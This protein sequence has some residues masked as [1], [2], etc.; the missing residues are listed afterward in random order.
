M[1]FYKYNGLGN[2]FILVE[3]SAARRV[4]GPLAKIMCDRHFG[5]GADGVLA[6]LPGPQP[7]ITAKM[8]IFN[9]D[10]TIAEMCG[11]GIRC[12]AYHLLRNG[13]TTSNKMQISTGAGIKTV[14]VEVKSAVEA[15]V[16]VDMGQVVYKGD[17]LPTTTTDGWVNC[18][19]PDGKVAKLYPASAGNPH[20]IIMLGQ[21][22]D[23]LE[24]AQQYGSFLEHHPLFP[25]KTNVEF[26]KQLSKDN[27]EVVVH[28]RGC[29]ITM[30]CGTGA[31]SVASVMMDYFGAPTD[32]VTVKLPGGELQFRRLSSGNMEMQG[33]TRLVFSG[34]AYL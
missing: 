17:N 10:G 26:V 12:L 9:S 7:E 28:E 20:C 29:G 21:N 34:E 3:G 15:L 16:T 24:W 5:I 6:V 13:W 18:R 30:A 11:N 19:L 25:A 31:T 33:K 32:K 22:D 8:V 14:Q 27:Y 2:D 1:H 4:N 23:P